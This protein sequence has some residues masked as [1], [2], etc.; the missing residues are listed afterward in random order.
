MP[1]TTIHRWDDIAAEQITEHISRRYVTGDGV[2]VARFALRKDGVVPRHSHPNEQ[3]SCVLSGKLEFRFDERTA[4]VGP[5]EVVQIPGDVP[6]E[7]AVLEDA[8][9]ID[10]FNPIRQDWIDRTDTYFTGAAR[11]E[12]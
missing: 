1:L 2:T 8:V 3:V 9:V 11:A 5:G 4:V 10:V 7:V 6:H 12:A